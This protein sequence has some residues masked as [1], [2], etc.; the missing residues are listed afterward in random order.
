MNHFNE[1][2]LMKYVLLYKWIY[3]SERIQPGVRPA[4]I[5]CVDPESVLPLSVSVCVF[6]F[7]YVS[8]LW[9]DR[10]CSYRTE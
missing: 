1:N 3:L 6:V 5:T 7:I 2:E 9:V 10:R 4:S 8:Y